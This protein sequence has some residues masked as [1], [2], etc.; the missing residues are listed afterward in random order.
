MTIK[1]LRLKTNM[2]QSEFAAYLNIPIANIQHWEQGYRNPPAYV[3][4]L[5][6]RI[7]E[8]DGYLPKSID[9]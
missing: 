9:I 3:L 7:I 5:V 2:S 1:E 6:K 8:N 4:D